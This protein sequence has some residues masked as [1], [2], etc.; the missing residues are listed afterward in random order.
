MR[1]VVCSALVAMLAVGTAS[2]DRT[3]A[4]QL[5]VEGRA[6]LEAND[7]AGACARFREAIALEPTAPG[8]MLNLGLCHELLDKYATALFWF[9]R[10]QIAA[11]EAKPPLVQY[12]DVAKAHT[13]DLAGRVATVRIDAPAGATV[14]I[15]DRQ[16][17]SVDYAR[18]EVDKDSVVEA[19]LPGKVPFRQ[20]LALDA[21]TRDGGTITVAFGES[22]DDSNGRRRTAYI[23]GASGI[24]V[25]GGTLAFAL[26]VRSKYNDETS[27]GRYGGLNPDSYAN[28]RDD[29]RYFGTGAFVL[30]TALVATAAYLYFTPTATRERAAIAPMLDGNTAGVA[31]GRSF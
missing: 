22:A 23:L 19:R 3:R 10:A 16:V 15:D 18:V 13:A 14:F 26:I 21:T 2:A 31:Y 30:G 20:Q 11:A 4:E 5:F 25:Y 1:R 8:V 28:A 6:R 12:E 27:T 24:A 7:A 29:L 17:Q 9:R